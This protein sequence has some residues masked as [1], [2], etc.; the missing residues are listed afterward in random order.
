MQLLILLCTEIK[1]YNVETNSQAVL[2]IWKN[3]IDD[4]VAFVVDV[5]DLG[6]QIT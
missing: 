1:W 6:F 2:G 4:L 5:P 3:G